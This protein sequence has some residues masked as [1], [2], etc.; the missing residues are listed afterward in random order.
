MHAQAKSTT[1]ACP[2][3]SASIPRGPESDAP[4]RQQPINIE[5]VTGCGVED[6]G[7]FPFAVKHGREAEAHDA[8]ATYTRSGRTTCTARRSADGSA[9]PN[10]PGV[11]LGIIEH[12]TASS[13]ANGRAI[14]TVLIGQRTGEPGSSS[15]R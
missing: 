7:Q 11:L 15:S 3:R 9:D 12:A 4:R 8:S 10:Q 1:A 14:D 2:G 13:E 5:G 6:G